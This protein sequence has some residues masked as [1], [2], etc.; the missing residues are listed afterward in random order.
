MSLH[1]NELKKIRFF[2]GRIIDFH[3]PLY[4]YLP[5]Y[6]RAAPGYY[7]ACVSQIEGEVERSVKRIRLNDWLH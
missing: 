3:K 2:P 4:F 7:E 5:I 1:Q 6:Q